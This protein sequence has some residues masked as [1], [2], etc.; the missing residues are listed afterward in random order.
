MEE[1]NVVFEAIEEYEAELEAKEAEARDEM[2]TDFANEP[3]PGDHREEIIRRLCQFGSLL[4]I[5][6][7]IEIYRWSEELCGSKH[8]NTTLPLYAVACLLIKECQEGR[9]GSE[10]HHRVVLDLFPTSIYAASKLAASFI[11]EKGFFESSAVICVHVSD[12]SDRFCFID[13]DESFQLPDPETFDEA[14]SY[15]RSSTI[16]FGHDT[17]GR[18]NGDRFISPCLTQVNGSVMRRLFF[19]YAKN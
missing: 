7:Y 17:I 6:E 12:A 14:I 8:R 16:V 5:P 18:S 15:V 13:L 2:Y 3:V 19:R 10:Q 4:T 1:I 9:E 11:G